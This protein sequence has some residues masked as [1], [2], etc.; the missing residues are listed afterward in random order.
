MAGVTIA[1]PR[2][3]G[4]LV[5]AASALLLAAALWFQFVEGLAPCTLCVWQRWPHVVAV[6]LAGVGAW[7]GWRWAVALAALALLGGAGVAMFHVGVEQG[8]WEGLATCSSGPIAGLSTDAL[9][10]Q[11]RNAPIARCDEVPWSLLGLSMAAW[12]GLASLGLACAAALAAAG[13]AKQA[14]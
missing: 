7:F 1:G 13:L 2:A 8:W 5:A 11:I 4:A 3:L 12:N 10:D 14:A 9:L 6:A